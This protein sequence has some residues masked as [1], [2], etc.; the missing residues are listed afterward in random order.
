VDTD[1]IFYRLLFETVR[2]GADSTTTRQVTRHS[3]I[4]RSEAVT[5]LFMEWEAKGRGRYLGREP[6][7][8]LA[9][10]VACFEFDKALLTAQKK[11]LALVR[12]LEEGSGR[13]DADA[14]QAY[15]DIKY[16]TGR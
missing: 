6:R 8:C 3:G 9:T 5:R 14:V 13:Q 15:I 2:Q 12:R 16:G 4:K 7:R 11:L 10:G 1:R